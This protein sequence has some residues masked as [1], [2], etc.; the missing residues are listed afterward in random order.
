MI[1]LVFLLSSLAATGAAVELPNDDEFIRVA[2]DHWT[3]QGAQSGRRF[4]PFGS[5]VTRTAKEDL[6]MFGPYYNPEEYEALLTACPGVGINVLKAFLPMAAWLPDPQVAGEAHI[7]PGYLEHLDDFLQR[8]RAHRIRV[9][10]CVTC[11][12]GNQCQLWQ[13]GGKYFGRSPWKTDAGLDSLDILC[14]FWTQ[15]GAHLRDNPTVFAY[16][17]TV[18]WTLPNGNLT[19]YPPKGYSAVLPDEIG[20]W[21]WRKWAEA[22]YGTIEKLNAAWDTSYKDWSEI[23]V[24]NYAY[25]APQHRYV[26]SENKIFDYSNFREWTTL[27]YFRPQIAAIRAADPKHMI[28][29]SNHMRFWDLWEGG[30]EHFLGMTPCEQTSLVDYISLHAN[31]SEGDNDPK[32]TD[33]DIIRKIEMLLRFGV[34]G[35]QIPIVLEEYSF[36]AENPA[37]TAEVQSAI[38]R[39]TVGHLSGWL[40]WYLQYPAR[41]EA[42]ADVGAQW[43]SAWLDADLKPTPWG[44]AAHALAAEVAA[45]DMGRKPAQLTVKLDRRH[46]LVPK[47]T[48]ILVRHVSEY[49][50]FPHPIDYTIEHEPDLDLKLPGEPAR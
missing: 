6:N 21:H 5:N 19:W 45:G 1:S 8:C 25:D 14:R 50:K 4:V 34:D 12:G 7:A 23:T 48:G 44:E 28:T 3:F 20:I 11:W 35:K 31:F 49:D 24:V 36:T 33:A 18:E 38:V 39:G 10:I 30:A 16:T 42:G 22:K 47:E 17:P 27:R 13:E 26:E 46:E 37:R 9:I 2:D 43:K 15:L 32:R 41:P 29:I 40:T